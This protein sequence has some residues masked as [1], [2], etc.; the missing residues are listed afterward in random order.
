MGEQA[1]QR[2]RDEKQEERRIA[3]ME[4]KRIKDEQERL[5]RGENSEDWTTGKTVAN[6]DSSNGIVTFTDEG[7]TDVSVPSELAGELAQRVADSQAE[8]GPTA[9]LPVEVRVNMSKKVLVEIIAPPPPAAAA[10]GGEGEEAG[11]EE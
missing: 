11:G 1:E 10:D 3:K 7:L 2:V 9:G 8:E 5:R 4:A 6:F